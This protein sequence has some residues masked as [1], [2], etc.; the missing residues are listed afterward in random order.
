MKNINIKVVSKE[1]LR[2]LD[3]IFRLRYN[4][5]VVEK[6]WALD[7]GNQME[8]DDYDEY[9]GYIAVV[10][11]NETTGTDEVIGAARFI[12]LENKAMLDG[13]FKEMAEEVKLIREGA[14]EFTSIAIDQKYRHQHLEQLIYQ[15]L[16]YWSHVWTP[17]T[18]SLL[19]FNFTSSA[20][21][22]LLYSFHCAK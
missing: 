7:F 5:F 13:E 8:R 19:A 3:G 9:A 14:I 1:E 22:K 17:P 2:V 4:V 10:K 20:Y 15:K 12:T 11:Q 18:P 16:I 6:G 21:M